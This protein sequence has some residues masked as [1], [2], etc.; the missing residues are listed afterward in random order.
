VVL[1]LAGGLTGILVGIASARI[2][3]HAAQWEVAISVPAVLLAFGFAAAVGVFFG[4]YP[5]RKAS[6]L[7]PIDALRYE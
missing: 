4:I 1:S 6:F 7:R 3:A 2:L 5:A